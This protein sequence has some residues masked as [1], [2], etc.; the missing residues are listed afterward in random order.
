MCGGAFLWCARHGF[1]SL[2]NVPEFPECEGSYFPESTSL[3]GDDPFMAHEKDW[4][5]SLGADN[6]LL[7]NLWGSS[8]HA[9]G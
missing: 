1:A 8:C 3:K 9:F 2:S 6:V 4:I 7:A 5:R